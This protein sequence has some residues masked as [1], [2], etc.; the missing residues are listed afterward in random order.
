MA[1]AMSVDEDE[2]EEE[3]LVVLEMT[4]LEKSQF[5]STCTHFSLTDVDS[6]VPVLRLRTANGTSQ[7]FRGSF[8]EVCGTDLIFAEN[9]ASR[10]SLVGQTTKR[11]LFQMA[12]SD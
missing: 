9:T 5:L 11:I 6:A 3:I 2:V 4:D 10:F 1:S 7:T 8:S 12:T